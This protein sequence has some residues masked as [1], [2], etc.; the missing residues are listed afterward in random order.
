MKPISCRGVL[1][2]PADLWRAGIYGFRTIAVRLA[3]PSNSEKFTNAPERGSQFESPLLHEEV[4]ANPPWVPGA[5]NPS[6]IY[7][8]SA[9]A[10]GA[11]P[12]RRRKASVAATKRKRQGKVRVRGRKL[13]QRIA[14]PTS[15]W[16]VKALAV[17][18]RLWRGPRSFRNAPLRAAFRTTEASEAA[19]P[20][21]R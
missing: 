17:E 10:N 8:V 7:C 19:V 1:P 14:W 4:A 12:A 20:Y 3:R 6:T 9:E 21:V 16:A 18:R 15:A 13:V 2:F 5:H 11:S